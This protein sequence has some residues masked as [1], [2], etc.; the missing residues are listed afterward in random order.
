[1]YFL[2][3]LSFTAGLITWPF[4]WTR[5]WRRGRPGPRFILMTF[6]LPDGRI[7]TETHNISMVTDKQSLIALWTLNKIRIRYWENILEIKITE[8]LTLYSH[9]TYFAHFS[10]V[11]KWVGCFPIAV[12]T[13]DVTKCN[14]DQRCHWQ[15][16]A[17]RRYVWTRL[18]GAISL[19]QPLRLV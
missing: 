15:K 18:K 6:T 1:M 17:K 10:S 3:Y 11:L 7:W 14:K 2:R 5:S 8:S 12:F 4:W 13:R 16:W 9:A 19:T